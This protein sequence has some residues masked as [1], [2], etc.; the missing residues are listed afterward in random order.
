MRLLALLAL[1][2]ALALPAAAQVPSAPEPGHLPV[3]GPA[4]VQAPSLVLGGAPGMVDPADEARCLE[5]VRAFVERAY[6][7]DFAGAFRYVRGLRD[8]EAPAGRYLE[9]LRDAR[10]SQGYRMLAECQDNLFALAGA[11]ENRTEG[12]PSS[13]D[14]L[15]SGGGPFPQGLPACPAHGTYGYRREGSADY[16]LWCGTDAHY[17][18]GIHGDRPRYTR[19]EGLVRGTEQLSLQAPAAFE[20]GEGT[21]AVE[22]YDE[23]YEVVLVRHTER[24]RLEPGE[25]LRERQSRF[26]LSRQDGLWRIDLALSNR[27]TL[28]VFDQEKWHQEST[29]ARQ[30]LFYYQLAEALGFQSPDIEQKALLEVRICEANLRSLS[31]EVERWSAEHHGDYPSRAPGG[32]QPQCPAGGVYRY[33]KEPD[34]SYRLW[35][36]GTAHQAAGLPADRPSLTPVLGVSRGR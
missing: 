19:R 34:G 14:E 35:C 24:S 26:V 4:A 29:L 15:V 22:D 27:D 30:I 9:F 16:Q 25:P 17:A 32:G 21:L 12:L 33:R 20:V 5:V 18:L 10:A 31:L 8:P 1:G 36:S 13:L 11:L 3:R 7:W 2:L 6:T 28:Y 23:D